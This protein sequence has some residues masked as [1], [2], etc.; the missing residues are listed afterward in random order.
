MPLEEDLAVETTQGFATPVQETGPIVFKE[1][2]L[3]TYLTFP[4]PVGKRM[5]I[6]TVSARAGV[7]AGQ[8]VQ[9]LLTATTGGGTSTFALPMIPQGQFPRQGDLF[10]TVHRVRAYAD[11]GSVVTFRIERSAAG[12]TD[13]G[14][15]SISGSLESR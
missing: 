6:D 3:E 10:A 8:K 15:V 11:G 2:E 4:V 7:G 1:G 9:I 14:F 5:L 13:S 12:E